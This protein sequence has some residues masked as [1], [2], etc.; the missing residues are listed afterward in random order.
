MRNLMMA[1]A[2]LFATVTFAQT[3]ETVT[4]KDDF[5]DPTGEKALRLITTGLFSNS[6]TSNSKTAAKVVVDFDYENIETNLKGSLD[7]YDYATPPAATLTYT[8]AHGTIKVKREDGTVEHYK[9]FA[10]ENGGMYF[11]QDFLDLLMQGHREK[12]Q[13]V[14]SERNFSKYGSSI[15]VFPLYTR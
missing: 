12:I 7:V 8:S 9:V 4:Y 10:S 5:G 2:L 6:A 15:Y 3:W 14:I 13:V 11:Y 1:V